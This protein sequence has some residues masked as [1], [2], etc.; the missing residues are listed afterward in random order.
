VADGNEREGQR[1][2]NKRESRRRR[3]VEGLRAI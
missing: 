3:K 2:R 1:K